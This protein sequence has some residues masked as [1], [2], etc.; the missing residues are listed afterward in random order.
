MGPA[1]ARP[2]APLPPEAGSGPAS[3]A[4]EAVPARGGPYLALQCPAAPRVRLPAPEKPVRYQMMI[5]LSS[6][7]RRGASLLL[8]VALLV[9]CSGGDSAST[10]NASASGEVAAAWSPAK[11]TA[12]N[13][14]SIDARPAAVK[15][16][17]D[18]ER[19]SAV[20]KE[21]WEHTR[22]LYQR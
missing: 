17:L 5:R 3:D 21:A 1:A 6:W 11:L 7:P 9:G 20:G 15:Q 2:V 22:R 19:P 16:R 14:V 8:P 10:S 13:G 4:P 18:G 12:V